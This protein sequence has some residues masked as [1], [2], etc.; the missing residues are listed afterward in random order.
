MSFETARSEL[1]RGLGDRFIRHAAGDHPKDIRLTFRK[2]HCVTGVIDDCCL[3]FK[4][5]R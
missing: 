4:V 2:S 5:K 3:A 1:P